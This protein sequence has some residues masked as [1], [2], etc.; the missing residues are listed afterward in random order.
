MDWKQEKI[1]LRPTSFE[2]NW[3]DMILPGK[4][5]V[6]FLD[7]G[8]PYEYT[9]E[10]KEGQKTIQKV[11]FGVEIKRFTGEGFHEVGKKD[12]GVTK[13]LT[14]NSL[15][16]QIVL[17]ANAG[18]GLLAGKEVTLIVLGSGKEIRYTVEEAL[19][20]MTPKSED[21]VKE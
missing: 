18:S 14:E 6:K 8:E 7:E 19:P 17:V 1:N 21:M 15:Y 4:Y 16:G 5:K 9:L 2:R 12:W 10:T 3:W 11:R 13:G 20:Y